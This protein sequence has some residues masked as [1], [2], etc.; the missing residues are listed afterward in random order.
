MHIIVALCSEF[1]IAANGTHFARVYLTRMMELLSDC[2]LSEGFSE[3]LLRSSTKVVY[4]LHHGQL[5]HLEDKEN[6]GEIQKILDTCFKFF[7][8]LI[9]KVSPH[10][11]VA[12]SITLMINFSASKSIRVTDFVTLATQ[13]PTIRP[14][15]ELIFQKIVE[16]FHE[17]TI[18]DTDFISHISE[19]SN[20]DFEAYLQW[21]IP[22]SI[23]S[24]VMMH[25]L[26][27]YLMSKVLTSTPSL[28][29]KWKTMQI[30]SLLLNEGMQAQGRRKK[31]TKFAPIQNLLINIITTSHDDLEVK[32]KAEELLQLSYGS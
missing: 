21:L 18:N 23:K 22:T 5:A 14:V 24:N 26:S 30:I 4:H 8:C 28:Q 17:P 29:A 20:S 7:K 25:A 16:G 13:R 31:N 11:Y 1:I 32:E 3:S 19:I 10:T 27:S 15:I 12:L 9:E 2:I 6:S